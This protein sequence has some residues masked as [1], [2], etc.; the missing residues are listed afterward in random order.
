MFSAASGES[1]KDIKDRLN[2]RKRGPNSRTTLKEKKVVVP[3]ASPTAKERLVNAAVE[4]SRLAVVQ[5]LN[6]LLGWELSY[7][8]LM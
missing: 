6:D 8:V 3:G 2:I 5:V 1:L 7:S 4:I